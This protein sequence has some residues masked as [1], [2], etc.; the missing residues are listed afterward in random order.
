MFL[1]LVSEYVS[2]AQPYTDKELAKQLR[3][4]PSTVSAWRHAPQFLEELSRRVR[5]GNNPEAELSILAMLRMA[6][7]GSIKAFEAAMRALGR[8]DSDLPPVNAPPGAPVGQFFGNVTF[9]NVPKPLS[10]QEAEALQPP[11]GSNVILPAPVLPPMPTR[12]P[13]R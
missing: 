13:P 4:Q 8:Y 10:R 6:Q 9:V 1:A 5:L 11:V 7:R 3:I 12:E 2:R